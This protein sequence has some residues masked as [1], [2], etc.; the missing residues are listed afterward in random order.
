MSHRPKM[1]HLQKEHVNGF[2]V[3]IAKQTNGEKKWQAYHKYPVMG[4]SFLHT[5]LG[6]PDELG[7]AEALYSFLN[8]HLTPYRKATLNFKFGIG[9]GYLTKKFDRLENYK[10]IVIGSHINASMDLRYEFKYIL[11]RNI[12]ISSGIGI[13]HF[14]NGAFKTP[15]LGVNIPTVNA[16]I[17]YYLDNKNS[18]IPIKTDSIKLKP[19]IYTIFSA[20]MKQIYPAY[21]DYYAAFALTGAYSFPLSNKRKLNAGLEFF[22]DYSN[23]RS[24]KRLDLAPKHDFQAYKAGIF[25]GHQIDFSKIAFVTE[26]GYYYHTLY[27]SDGSLYTRLGLRYSFS[28]RLFANLCLKTHYAKADFVEWGIGYRIKK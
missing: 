4:I 19:G 8:F 22:L 7:N 2:S 28:D 10:N 5:T 14:S 24:L 21:G 9:L 3:S 6:N 20:G 27:K 12:M 15:N 1:R 18:F 11:T 26:L 23:L 13:T 17:T 25:I 16:G